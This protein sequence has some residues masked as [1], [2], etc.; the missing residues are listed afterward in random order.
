MLGRIVIELIRNTR[1]AEGLDQPGRESG[2]AGLGEELIEES[3]RADLDWEASLQ[4]T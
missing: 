1:L 2:D 4:V 3:H